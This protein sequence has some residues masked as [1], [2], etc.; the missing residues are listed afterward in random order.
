MELLKAKKEETEM[1]LE[2]LQVLVQLSLLSFSPTGTKLSISNNE[3]YL[4]RPYW[5]QGV[6]RYYNQDNKDDLYYLYHSIRRFFQWYI[7]KNNTFYNYLLKKAS[8]GLSKLIETYSNLNKKNITHTL[9]VYKNVLDVQNPELFKDLNNSS[10][11]IDD[12]FSGIVDIYSDEII[13]FLAN[14]FELLEKEKDYAVLDDH[15]QG[16]NLI[17]KSTNNKIKKWISENLIC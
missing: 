5:L 1:I 15:I 10:K 17:L 16:I 2:P 13:S 6:L 9:S 7:V 14:V 12:V 11:S 3:L 8:D 4:Q